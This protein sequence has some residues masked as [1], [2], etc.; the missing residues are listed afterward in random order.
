MMTT[1]VTT[2]VPSGFDGKAPWFAFEDA[3][4]DWCE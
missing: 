4:D 3:V 2:K 1:Q